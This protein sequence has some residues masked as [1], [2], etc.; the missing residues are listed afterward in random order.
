MF[1]ESP[2]QVCES[3]CLYKELPF[4]ELRNLY[5]KTC[6]DLTEYQGIDPKTMAFKEFRLPTEMFDHS[7]LINVLNIRK[8]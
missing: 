4:K 8:T 6:S 1:K 7:N 5:T 3:D 2:Y